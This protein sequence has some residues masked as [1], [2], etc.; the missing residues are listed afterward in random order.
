MGEILAIIIVYGCITLMG[1]VALI[2]HRCMKHDVDRIYL[3]GVYL[4]YISFQVVTCLVMF[5]PVL[6][7]VEIAVLGIGFKHRD[8]IERVVKSLNF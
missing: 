2:A 7:G 8:S 6:L 5:V 3:M 4:I 1:C